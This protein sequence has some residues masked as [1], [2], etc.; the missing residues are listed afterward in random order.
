MIIVSVKAPAPP[1]KCTCTV[2]DYAVHYGGLAKT[3]D[4]LLDVW[5]FKGFIPPHVY[6]TVLYYELLYKPA[7][8]SRDVFTYESLAK[9]ADVAR[10]VVSYD[11][12]VK[13][14][15]VVLEKPLV[16]AEAK[17]V[18]VVLDRPLVEVEAKTATTSSD[19]LVLER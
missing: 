15:D 9:T 11:S 18:D 3:P 1:A 14:A 2:V 13:T 6:L 19:I 17:T 10:D 7:D 4:L 12:A 8:A 16:E 5:E